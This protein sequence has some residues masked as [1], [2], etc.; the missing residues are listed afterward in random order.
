MTPP[1][2]SREFVYIW[3]VRHPWETNVASKFKC[4]RV[5]SLTLHVCVCVCDLCLLPLTTA[6]PPP[7]L[8]TVILFRIFVIKVC[9]FYFAISFASDQ[10][11]FSSSPSSSFVAWILFTI[12]VFICFQVKNGHIS[13]FLVIYRLVL[14]LSPLPMSLS[15]MIRS[16]FDYKIQSCLCIFH[17]FLI[18]WIVFSLSVSPPY[19][20]SFPTYNAWR[21]VKVTRLWRVVDIEDAATVAAAVEERE[22]G[23]SHCQQQRILT[24]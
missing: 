1:N 12:E 15:R 17:H 18:V 6:P 24:L 16:V 22:E 4:A 14:L 21:Q 19:L 11:F 20:F 9:F 3:F 7:S 10:L 5:L 8:P 13:P 2:Q 23:R